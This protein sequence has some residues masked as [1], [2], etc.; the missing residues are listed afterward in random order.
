[1]IFKS[2]AHIFEPGETPSYSVSHLAQKYVQHSWISKNTLKWFGTVAVRLNLLT[3]STVHTREKWRACRDIS[4]GTIMCPSSFNYWTW[5]PNCYRKHWSNLFNRYFVSDIAVD[6][7]VNCDHRR[8]LA[9][10]LAVIR[11]GSRRSLILVEALKSTL[12]CII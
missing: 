6:I 1:M 3:I 11:C 9:E 8:S 12:G 4:H 2:V 5:L 7:S 10:I